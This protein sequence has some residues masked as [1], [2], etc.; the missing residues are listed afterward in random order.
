MNK[1]NKIYIKIGVIILVIVICSILIYINVFKP[2]LEKEYISLGNKYLQEENYDES[3]ISFNKLIKI[4]KKNTD[5]MLGLSKAYIGKGSYDKAIEMLK[6][7]Q[8]IDIENF[9]LLLDILD[10][11]MNINA[12]ISYEIL[13]NYINQVGERNIDNEVKEIVELSKENPVNPIVNPISGKYVKPVEVKLEFDKLRVGHSYYYTIDGSEPSKKSNKYNTSIKVDRDTKIKLIGYN[14]YNASTEIVIL[15]YIIDLDRKLDLEKLIKEVQEIV[16]KTDVGTE[17]GNVDSLSKEK[18]SN[19][20]DKASSLLEKKVLS[21]EEVNDAYNELERVFND[22]KNSI[23]QSTDKSELSKNIDKAQ[24]LY[25]NSTEG[26]RDGQYKVGSKKSLLEAI[27][28]ARET[29]ANCKN[30]EI[31]DR[32]TN[33]LKKAISNFESADE[34][35]LTFNYEDR[36]F[37]KTRCNKSSDRKIWSCR[38]WRE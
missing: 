21:Y 38:I 4:N 25:E 36:E 13:Q 33:I 7:A 17:I 30:Q 20:I 16:N 34:R 3:I 9:Q 27:N 23:I 8:S 5:A 19:S 15:D 22:F 24:K 29:Y 12:D 31:V 26:S 10:I 35:L 11:M 1:L 6:K 37:F 18:V 14:K 2:K 28:N 32:E